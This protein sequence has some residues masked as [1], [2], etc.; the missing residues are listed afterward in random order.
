MQYFVDLIDNNEQLIKFSIGCFE[1]QLNHL[2][3]GIA[4]A[5]HDNKSINS[6][7]FKRKIQIIK[8]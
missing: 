4:N 2:F 5:I 8:N 1:P 3:K 7:K 6:I